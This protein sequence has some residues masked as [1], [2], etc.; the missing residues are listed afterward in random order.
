MMEGSKC[1]LMKKALFPSLALQQYFL[2]LLCPYLCVYFHL[3]A[4]MCTDILSLKAADTQLQRVLQ[5]EA[6]CALQTW[7]SEAENDEGHISACLFCNQVVFYSSF[8]VNIIL[9]IKNHQEELRQSQRHVTGCEL[10][11]GI[12]SFL[13]SFGIL[14]EDD[15]P[16][17]LSPGTCLAHE[18]ASHF[19]A[20][21]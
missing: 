19:L 10:F 16:T 11:R 4:C 20:L 14:Q 5:C 21:V 1:I 15:S 13:L 8:L 12:S 18:R 2:V 17:A 9:V 7:C 6:A 3:Y